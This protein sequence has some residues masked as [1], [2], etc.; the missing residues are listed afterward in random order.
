MGSTIVFTSVT[1]SYLPNAR[2]LARSVKRHHPA[3]TMVLLLNDLEP[4]GVRWDEEPFDSVFFAHWLPVPDFR[5]WAFDHTIV[6]FCTATKGV[7]TEVLFGDFGADRVIYLDPDTVVFSAFSEVERLL[8]E[9]SVILTPHLTDRESVDEAIESHEIAALKHGTLNLGF[10]AVANRPAGQ[11][12]L[13]WW[14]DRCL[15][16][17][18]IDFQAGLFTD[19]KWCNLAPYLF[20]DI[21]VLTDRAYNVATWNMTNRAMTRDGETWL[22]NGRPLRFYHFSG[23][24]NDFHWANRELSM[25]AEDG[26]AL[27]DLW[28]WY[29][30]ELGANR[31]REV[32]PWRWGHFEHGL[33]VQPAHRTIYREDER[34]REEQPDPYSVSC[35]L[36]LA[37][38]PSGQALSRSAS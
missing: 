27:V 24:G 4:P 1:G 13:R 3:W 23:F 20:E 2:V 33:P 31:L 30:A 14:T 35:Y 37:E 12:Y 21:H 26:S 8:D 5:R 19:Q 17:S 9:H 18:R 34:L 15:R 11:D 38:H 28:T 25:F 32:P 7:M 6:E 29:K 36:A 10:Y 16:F 22:I